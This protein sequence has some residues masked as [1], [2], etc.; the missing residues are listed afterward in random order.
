MKILA[1]DDSQAIRHMVAATLIS[2]GFEV[3]QAEDGLAG[4]QLA[5]D[6]A[7]D[8]ILSD[9]NMPNMGGYEFVAAVR[10]L[11]E[12]KYTPI[13]MLTTEF[14][15]NKKQAGRNAGANGWIIKPID[16]DQLLKAVTRVTL[17]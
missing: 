17:G 14:E 10:S 15:D 11:A 16:P 7:Y 1:V 5:Q 6:G 13:L 12:H 8:L 9:V 2:N 3:E 4:L